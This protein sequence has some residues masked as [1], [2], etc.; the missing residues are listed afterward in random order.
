MEIIV[1]NI[2]VMAKSESFIGIGKWENRQVRSGRLGAR[3]SQGSSAAAAADGRAGLFSR[4]A[5]GCV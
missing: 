3:G 2:E 4:M 1:K 5:L